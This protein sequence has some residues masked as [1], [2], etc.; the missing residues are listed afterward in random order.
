MGLQHPCLKDR[1][2][3]RHPSAGGIGAQH[4]PANLAEL[5]STLMEEHQKELRCLHTPDVM[6]TH[7]W[8][9]GGS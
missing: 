2:K 5:A 3:H 4:S 6:E 1:P 8:L 7:S 9:S